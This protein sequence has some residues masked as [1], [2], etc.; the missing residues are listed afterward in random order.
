VVS[1]PSRRVI[2]RNSESGQAVIKI[3]RQRILNLI[4]RHIVFN[5]IVPLQTSEWLINPGCF[6]D[7]S[8]AAQAK[9][10][11]STAFGSNR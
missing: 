10:L 4:T 7:G 3:K 1:I 5:S 6:R 2:A 11:T 8:I 9:R